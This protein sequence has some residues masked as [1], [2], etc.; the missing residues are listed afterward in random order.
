MCAAD[1][2]LISNF[3]G[4]QAFSVFNINIKIMVPYCMSTQPG[5]RNTSWSVDAKVF[6]KLI[7]AAE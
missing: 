5:F 3:V 4:T 6:I 7:Y 2:F 1:K